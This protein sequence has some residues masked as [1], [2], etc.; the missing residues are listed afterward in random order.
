MQELS[1]TTPHD[2]LVVGPG[3]LGRLIA[4]LWIKE[5]PSCTVVGQTNTTNH[6]EELRSLGIRPVVKDKQAGRRF[7]YIT[8][9][10]PP[11]ASADYAAELR[12]AAEQWNGE[13]VF[14]FTSSSAV[15]D[16]SD[17]GDCDEET[18][19]VPFGRGPR[20]DILLNAEKEVLQAEGTI[21]RLAGLYRWDRGPHAYWAKKGMVDARPDHILN[22]IHYEDAASLC[23]TILRKGYNKQV[24]MGC[25][26]HP[27]SRQEVM[28]IVNKSGK[29]D[30]KFTAFTA[31]DGPLGKK[32]NCDKTR[33]QT[34]WQ[35]KY[36]NF[37]E[38][39]GAAM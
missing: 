28:D 17:N 11:S 31:T 18:P 23:V 8:F 2:L 21:V 6:H 16:R 39:C 10:A 37:A 36:K 32:M 7:P 5:N 26:N 25:D 24:F 29:L 35:P 15:Y 20:T 1:P 3:V 34:G 33:G 30:D 19:I 13:G 27:L 12:S 38:F 9:C 14:L 22:L 4:Q